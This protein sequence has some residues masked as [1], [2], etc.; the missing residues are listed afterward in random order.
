[1]KR[2]RT[3]V[4][5]ALATLILLVAGAL[6]VAFTGAI[7]VAASQGRLPGVDWYL[8]IT[9]DHSIE[10]R[11]EDITPPAFNDAMRREGL[12][13]YHEMCVGCHGAPGIDPDEIGQGLNPPPPD[14]TIPRDEPA[15][16]FW[17]VKNGIRMTGMPAFGATHSD[18]AI[19][20]ITAFLQELP[21][22]T[23]DQYAQQVAAQGLELH[24][25]EHEHGE[26]H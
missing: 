17:V 2:A 10:A 4:L 25:E 13:H 19:W 1:M 5:T 20:N 16:D 21:T 18:E 6:V 14:L 22:L 3:V 12:E 24:R 26:E 7:N 9:S 23:A 11:A 8:E 15:E